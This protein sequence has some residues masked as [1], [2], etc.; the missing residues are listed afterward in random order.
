MERTSDLWDP[1]AT[2]R[3][4]PIVP[5]P[6]PYR[7]TVA[8]VRPTAVAR[9]AGARRARSVPFDLLARVAA[10]AFDR[11]GIAFVIATFGYRAADSGYLPIAGRDAGGYAMLALLSLGSASL[12]AFAS[13]AVF[14]TTL[15]KL[16]FALH[17]RRRDGRR[18][19]VGRT[20]VRHVL[21]PLDALAIGALLAALTPRRQR[22]GDLLADTVV[23]RSPMGLFAS[24]LGVLVLGGVGYAQAAYGGGLG[25]ARAV[26]TETADFGP[27]L[28]ARVTGLVRRTPIPFAATSTDRG[29]P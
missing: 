25:S 8:D 16:V 6:P 12:V 21:A 19:G 28:M 23:S 17:V 27:D 2:T 20:I 24:L 10:C 1:N 26:A 18:V 4:I 29:A 11:V 22:L 3:S 9:P 13:E 5:P 14:G 15:G 7:G